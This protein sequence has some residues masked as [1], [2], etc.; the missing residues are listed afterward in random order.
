MTIT[1]ISYFRP[2]DNMAASARVSRISQY[3]ERRG[4]D[5][6]VIAPA[7][8]L[9]TLAAQNGPRLLKLAHVVRAI[10]SVTVAALRD[11]ARVFYV[12]APP[13][14]MLIPA[15]MLRLC[16][17]AALVFEER[18]PLT[19]NTLT[20]SKWISINPLSRR[21][22][23]WLLLRADMLVTATAPALEQLETRWPELRKSGFAM[24]ISN[25]F[26]SKDY[27]FMVPAVPR[28]PGG[29]LQLVHAGNFYGTRNPA[30]L[31]EALVAMARKAPHLELSTLL[32]FSFL[33]QFENAAKEQTFR[34]S[35][36]R[37]GLEKLF[38]LHGPCSR[39]RTLDAIRSADVA[40]LITHDSGSEYAVPAKMY[41]YI[42]LG[43]PI[44]AISQ[45]PL[46][47]RAVSEHGLGWH[48]SHGATAALEE[49]L[50]WLAT[51]AEEVRSMPMP[52][53]S[54]AACDAEHQLPPLEQRLRD[55]AGGT[56]V[57]L[58]P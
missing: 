45:D 3:L 16:K 20:Q 15:F 27:Q 11:D 6:R 41:E 10:L 17:S 32:H 13:V 31:V 51:H 49:K 24:T 2:E 7:R 56:V 34:D 4:W 26:W 35:I 58:A 5:V 40:I 22:E 39:S 1:I 8:G 38:T 33:G 43:K 12:T 46:V 23:R 44:L 25:G 50:L 47:V 29:P 52:G 36:A 42:A 18:D 14:S 30:P 53:L 21:L 48:F 57:A 9:T 54:L 55:L 19:T 37:Y 28:V